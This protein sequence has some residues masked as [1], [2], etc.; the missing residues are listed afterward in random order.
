M[1]IAG[2]A[3]SVLALSGTTLVLIGAIGIQRFDDPF[4][5]MH[6]ATKPVTLGLVLVLGGAA[7]E[8][9][10]PAVTA[11]LF[12]AAVFQFATAPMGMVL[13]GRS[14]Y[15]AGVELSPDLVVDE[16]AAD[17]HRDPGSG[18]PATAPEHTEP[19]G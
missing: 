16:L 13:L 17:R 5:R 8:A 12:L 1:S 3:T 6:A 2:I 9:A 18:G 4:A 11:Q 7:I 19:A 14:A 10:D 15:D